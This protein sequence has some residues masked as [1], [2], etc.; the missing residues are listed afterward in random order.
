VTRATPDSSGTREL[1]VGIGVLAVVLVVVYVTW[2]STAWGHTLDNDAYFGAGESARGVVVADRDFLNDVTR[3]SLGV[4]LIVLLVVS[5]VRRILS[6]GL[7]AVAGVIVA[8]AGAEVLKR[9]LS[10]S[11]LVPSDASLGAGLRAETYPSGHATIGT[12]VALAVVMLVPVGWRVWAGLGAGLLSATF[13]TAVVIAG[14]HRP[15]DALGG[16]CWAGLVMAIAALIAVRFRQEQ[17]STSI[18]AN[19]RT[20]LLRSNAIAAV[21]FYGALLMLASGSSFEYPDADPAFLVTMAPIVIAAFSV[22]AWFADSLRG[23]VWR[24]RAL[25]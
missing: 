21:I 1:V 10:W 18:P 9:T 13:A 3:L 2:V 4:G 17:E 16:V 19:R 5:L 14:W 8:V 23:A 7:I 25:A 20:S 24:E 11:E 12:S 22:T 15:S 6:V